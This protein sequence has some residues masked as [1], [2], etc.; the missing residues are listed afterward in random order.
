MILNKSRQDFILKPQVK[1]TKTVE[2]V[3]LQVLS[4]QLYLVDFLVYNE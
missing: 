3:Q 4:V 1:K 2:A